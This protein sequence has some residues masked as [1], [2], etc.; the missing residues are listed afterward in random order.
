MNIIEALDDPHLL[1]ASIRDA[2]FLAALAG[3]AGGCFR[4]AA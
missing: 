3:V 1:G 2:K 4:L